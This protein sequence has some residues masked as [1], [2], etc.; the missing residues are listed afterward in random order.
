MMQTAKASTEGNVAFVA[1]S[2]RAAARKLAQ[3]SAD[4]RNK[5][6]LAAAAAI[7]EN[8]REILAANGLDCQSAKQAVASG[9]MS[10]AMFARLQINERGI[11][12]MA[13]QVREVAAPPDPLGR[14]LEATEL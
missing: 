8:G 13:K 14:L 1:L 6:L 4:I 5:V 7:E 9:M 11:D 2:A 12:Q 3:L 10:P